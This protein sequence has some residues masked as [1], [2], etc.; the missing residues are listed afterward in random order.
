MGKTSCIG[1]TLAMTEQQIVQA[2]FIQN[3]NLELAYKNESLISSD[4]M[5]KLKKT[6]KRKLLL[7]NKR[8]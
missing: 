5:I 2:L 4:L 1:K 3:Y 7:I 6:L 8:N